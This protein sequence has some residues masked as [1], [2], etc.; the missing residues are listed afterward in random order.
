MTKKELFKL[1]ED[2]IKKG[3]TEAH[4]YY[5]AKN[6]K[7]TAEVNGE[8]FEFHVSNKPGTASAKD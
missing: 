2:S 4:I 1:I 7:F 8:R 5:S 6:K 3:N